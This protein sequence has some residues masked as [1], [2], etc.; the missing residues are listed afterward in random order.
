MSDAVFLPILGHS[1]HWIWINR[2]KQ[3]CYRSLWWSQHGRLIN[4][5]ACRI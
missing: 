5:V 3:F 4:G 2:V 1:W